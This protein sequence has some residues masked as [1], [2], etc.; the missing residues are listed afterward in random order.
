MREAFF[1]AWRRSPSEEE[2]KRLHS[3]F[4]APCDFD[5]SA[6]AELIIPHPGVASPWSSK[7]GE[8]LRNCGLDAVVRAEHGRLVSGGGAHSIADAMTQTVLPA[9]SLGRW[10]E[11]FEMRPR[12]PLAAVSPDAIEKINEE[13][14]LALSDAEIDH[15]KRIC[16]EEGRDL[17]DAEILMFA[18]A[19]S[20]HCRHKIFRGA[21][22]DGDSLMARIRRTHEASPSGV[23]TAFSDNAAVIQAGDG[24]DFAPGADSVY[25]AGRGGLYLAAKAE[26]HNH[27]TAISP[28]AGAATGAGGEIR[29]EAAAGRGAASRAGF[30]GYIVSRLS[31]ERS[32]PP[33]F[34]SPLKIMQDAPLGAAGY[35]NEFGRPTLAGFFRAFDDFSGPRAWGFD[36]PVMLAGGIGHMRAGDEG[37]RPIPPGAKFVQIGGPGFRIGMGGGAA[38]SR[39]A[40]GR[41]FASVQRDNAEIERRAQE[42]IDACRRLFPGMLLSL[43][44]V[45]AG[46][47]ANAISE[48]AHDAGMGA[49]IF[50]DAIP[51][52]DGSLSPAELWCNE[53]QERYV[54][55]IKADSMADFEEICRRENCPF[56][57][58][59]EAEDTGRIVLQDAS[60]QTAV[61]LSLEK[62]LGDIPQPLRRIIPALAPEQPNGTRANPAAASTDD[63]SLEDYCRKILR[64]PAVACRRFLITIGDRTVGGLTARDQMAGRWQTPVS[65][66]AAI[67]NDFESFGGAAFALGE[68]PPVS[69]LNPAAGA[70]IAVA[71]ALTNLA[72]A[73]IGELSRVKLSLNW[74]ANCADDARAAELRD[75]V[76]AASEFCAAL[77][78][79]V[80][81]GKDSL[82]MRAALSR[83]NDLAPATEAGN[84]AA[85]IE[86]PAFAAAFAF[87][88]V[89]DARRILTPALAGGEDSFIML[90]EPSGMRRLG[91]SVFSALNEKDVSEPPDIGHEEMAAFWRAM[92]RCHSEDLLSA[93]HDRSDGGLWA[94]SCEMA[95]AAN[96][97]LTL[98]LDGLFPAPLTD[99]G[100]AGGALSPAQMRDLRAALFCEEPGALLEA[101]AANAPRV[102]EIFADEGLQDRIQTVARPA[103][104]RRIQIYCG[105]RKLLDCATG[106]LRRNWEELSDCIARKRGDDHKCA[107]EEYTRDY[108]N[109]RGLFAHVPFDFE[110]PPASQRDCPVA[111]SGARPRAAILREQGSNGQREM[112]AAFARAGFEAVDVTMSDLRTGRRTLREFRGLA[113]C[114]GFSFGDVLGAGRGWAAGVLHDESLADMF[115]EFFADPGTF[116]FG[117]CNGCQALALLRPLMGD[118]DWAFPRFTP[119]RSGRFEARLAMVEILD[120]PSLFFSGMEGACMPVANSNAEGCAD[121]ADSLRAPAAMRFVGGDGKPAASHPHNPSG[122]EACGF[123]SPDGRITIVMP[124]PE[125]SFRSAQLSWR[126]PEWKGDSS[127]WMRMFV[128]A[129]RFVG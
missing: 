115:K 15:L 22:E 19:N 39:A 63:S 33:G 129:R 65:D 21:W 78:T 32:A 35:C 11:L 17:T 67:F 31:D 110:D 69:A 53:S 62:I 28:F 99:G 18:Q 61:D 81:V 8:I 128:N 87:V 36:K 91:G 89:D 56:A 82:F 95:F 42:A 5:E 117:A 125:R 25:A 105:G 73:D 38:S 29:D 20:E 109:D 84:G 72:A 2:K 51:A 116:A 107:Q 88:P 79:G 10:R 57:V 118:G 122:G 37:K 102:M 27:P 86:S 13:Q 76:S 124:H 50:L 55:A 104:A 49:R 106:E 41:D 66:C 43:H 34:A 48:M 121:F 103:A 74:M 96:C 127:P 101:P 30:A 75:A 123:S 52:D 83:D 94:A 111:Q 1:V 108:E 68:R 12:G 90:A 114:G 97:G 26:T 60:G 119:N 98:V 58:L 9:G 64:H 77:R 23:V 24:E 85:M 14:G 70:R 45:G 16:A 47:L 80:I 120:S 40:G 100:D 92:S 6:D 3:L 93:Y 46:G 54:L 4:E 112:A 126:P 59:G 113:M 71:E 44:D 7:A